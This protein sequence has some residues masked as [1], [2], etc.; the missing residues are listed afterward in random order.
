MLRTPL[1]SLVLTW[2]LFTS[3]PAQVDSFRPLGQFL[4][5]GGGSAE[6]L[7]VS[8][9]GNTLVYT[10]AETESIGLVDISVPSLPML[11]GEE[12]SVADEGE[13][14]SA[15]ISPNGKFAF[16]AVQKSYLEED[17]RPFVLP[18]NL[19]VIRLRDGRRVNDIRIGPGPDS[20]AAT[21]I[22]GETVVV[23]AIENEP[24]IVDEKGKLLDEDAP[25][26]PR[27]VSDVGYV[28]VIRVNFRDIHN[29]PV[30][31]V[32]LP[33]AATLEG[34][35]LAFPEDPQPEFVSIHD[36][37]LV[38]VSLQENNGIAIIDISDPSSPELV[39]VF[40]LGK[41]SDRLADLVED[42]QIL[43]T[44]TY[45][46]D[47]VDVEL[48]GARFPD[49]I[50]WTP[51]GQ[52]IVSA[53]EG[54]VNFSGG[55]GFSIWSPEGDF[56]WDDGGEVEAHAVV[57]G[58]YPEGRSENKGV[59][60][61]GVA[62]G[63]FGGKDFAIVCSERGSFVVVYDIT[64]PT[65]PVLVQVLPTGIAPEGVKTIPSRNLFLTA[66]EGDDGN[67]SISFYEGMSGLYEP[68][69]TRPVIYS[70]T[71][72]WSAL[73]GLA[74]SPL[75]PDVLYSVPDSALIS[76]IYKIEVGTPHVPLTLVA[77]VTLDG[78]RVTYDLEGI[79][80]DTS[81]LAPVD[82]GF[83]L[84]CEGDGDFGE[85]GHLPNLLVQVNASGEVLREIA[86]PVEIEP[87]EE[88]ADATGTVRSNGFE[89]VTL[90]EDGRYLLAA[91]QRGFSGE[92]EVDGV[93]YTRIGRYDLLDETWEFFLYPLEATSIS[94]DWI[95]LSEITQLGSDVYAVIERD[96][97][98]GAAATIKRIYTFSL[99]GVAPFEGPLAADSDLTGQVISK[100]LLADIVEEFAPF[101][102]IEGL[103]KTIAGNFWALLDNDGGELESRFVDL[104]ALDS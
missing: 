20:V 35:G 50:A 28:Q 103:A 82:A 41:V 101:E 71:V 4:V 70:E 26:D 49:A 19:L 61:E 29:S 47:V 16:V 37:H 78:E 34:L 52:A 43:L 91:I 8:P 65:A 88:P 3:A 64:D 22:D 80:V 96:K 90:S 73:S 7:S 11:I 25:G 97:Q 24:I 46:A 51:D 40:P 83:W 74:A 30:H 6:I 42:E 92:P 10:S 57:L 63:R 59:E 94:G 39:R 38:A 100:T 17:E 31:T 76:E 75:N 98:F 53:D 23:V 54:E 33:D 104:G 45:P 102:K 1:P 32:H 58:H 66:D 67:G 13:P 85:E 56:L 5:P 12:I 95:G 18:G 15:A 81:I 89:G 93:L 68:P 60:M 86:L 27:D 77:P 2:L 14:T 21:E 55:R 9:D 72:A 62:T 48:A 79:V 44:D 69:V 99:A 84:A 87:L 36:D